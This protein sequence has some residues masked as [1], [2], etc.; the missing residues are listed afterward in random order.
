MK[1]KDLF[2]L[3]TQYHSCWWPG[4]A[5]SPGISSHGTGL[6]IPEYSS[7]IT[8]MINKYKTQPQN[9]KLHSPG[10][11]RVWGSRGVRC[12]DEEEVDTRWSLS[13]LVDWCSLMLWRQTRRNISQQ[14]PNS[15]RKFP[16]NF[17]LALHV[18]VYIFSYWLV[19]L[20]IKF[21]ST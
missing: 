11:N 19:W 18:F 21:I 13:R 15:F 8:R 1:D 3:H 17:R 7:F 2:I 14:I 4:D 20:K 6:I 12:Q 16:S 9:K 5:R 10:M